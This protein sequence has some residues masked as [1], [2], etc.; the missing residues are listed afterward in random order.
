M[1][2]YQ[3]ILQDVP[4]ARRWGWRV[5]QRNPLVYARGRIRHADHK[6]IVL[7][8]WHRVLMNTEHQAVAMRNVVFLD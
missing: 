8:G 2:R 5:M 3:Q 1:K 7:H 4:E 6:T